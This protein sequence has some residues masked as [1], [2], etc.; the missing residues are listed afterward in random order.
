MTLVTSA[1]IFAAG[2]HDG[3]VRR[4]STTPYIVH[5]MEAA[6]IAAALT[7]DEEV[8]A[9]AVLHDVMEDCGISRAELRERFGER[10]AS[11]VEAE[12]QTQGAPW[13]ARK[14]E[15]IDKLS[16][17]DRVACILALADKLSNMR[18]IRRDYA[19]DG[20]AMF[21]KF[22]ESD[23]EKHAWYYRACTDLIARELGDTDV[24]RELDRLVGE[25]FGDNFPHV[26]ETA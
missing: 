16:R 23:K 15:T 9:A 13:L 20:E 1:V 8:I 19:R 24:W 21:A 11:L 26:P 12:S 17:G 14:R 10:V 3:M 25:V 5:P 2:L 6:V 7:R 22:H 4:G 18:A